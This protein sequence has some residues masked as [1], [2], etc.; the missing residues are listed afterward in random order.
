MEI[1]KN[2]FYVFIFPGL[3]FSIIFG[4]LLS[5]IDRKMVARM[6]R[7]I[8]PPIMQP[9]YDILKLTGKERLIPRR[10]AKNTFIL[11]PLIGL[12]SVIT[13]SLFIPF[14][15][16]NFFPGEYGDIIVILYLLTIPAV[17]LII[18]G[19][20]S[21]SPYASIGISREMVT[22]LS[23]EVPLVII[24]LAVGAKAGFSMQGNVT[25]SLKIIEEYQRIKGINMF[26]IYLI[27]AAL[28]FLFIIP[29]EVG[30]VPFD[31]AEAETEIC[32]GP[33]VEYSGIYLGIYKLTGAVKMFIMGNLF[34]SLF[35]G[36]INFGN[37]I[38][39][40]LF[41]ILLII[42]VIIISISFVRSIVGRIRIEQTLR[43]FWTIPTILAAIS[44]VFAYI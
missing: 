4:L 7:R 39:N 13:I 20:A 21:G 15:G 37:I 35:L 16:M 30:T 27:P 9:F 32:E 6:Q 38:L 3:I 1:L 14:Y 2:L 40:V 31:I 43:F 10:A 23:Y 24:L 42:L 17:A 36:G 29:A 19:A 22:M 12:I 11:A 26:N 33:L 5:G 41:N 25:F 8:G 18:G 34:V 44:L 28:A